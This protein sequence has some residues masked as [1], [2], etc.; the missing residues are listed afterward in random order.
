MALKNLNIITT[1]I[2]LLAINHKNVCAQNN[3]SKC[4]SSTL[5]KVSKP[6]VSLIKEALLMHDLIIFDDGIHSAKEPFD[7][8]CRL[9]SDTTVTKNLNYIFLEVFNTNSQNYLDNYF[10]SQTPDSLLLIKAFQDDYS[11]FGWRYQTYL[12]LFKSIHK[13]NLTRKNK[14]KV[15]AVSP[16]IFWDGIKTRYDFETF[17]NSLSSRDYFM[18]QIIKSQM[19]D[20][21]NG[22]KGFFLTN[23]RHAYKNIK[24]STGQLYWNT[25]TF[26]NQRDPG[27]TYSIR[28]HN[29]SI[30]I[31]QKKVNAGKITTEGLNEF[32]YKW[33]LPENGLWDSTFIHANKFPYAIPLANNCFG[34]SKYLGNLMINVKKGTTQS[35]TYDALIALTP[36]TNWHFSST[37]NFIYTQEFKVELKRRILLMQEGNLADFL[38]ENE[39]E[40][41]ERFIELLSVATPVQNNNLL[42]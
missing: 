5:S 42:R 11:G 40:S 3:K 33:I 16:P 24:D 2:V 10:N 37:I 27:K 41:V 12:D 4:F 30:S 34:Q 38:K 7:F 39:A 19:A 35:D 36:F 23:T 8:Y 21:K 15:I 25:N 32:E 9:I 1:F 14:I 17:Q 29:A 13:S 26:F 20:F 31:T 6:P 18:Y 28:I 22:E